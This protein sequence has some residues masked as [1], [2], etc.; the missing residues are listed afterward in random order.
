MEDTKLVEDT[1]D[2]SILVVLPLA[3]ISDNKLKSNQ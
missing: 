1:R 3:A 2:Y